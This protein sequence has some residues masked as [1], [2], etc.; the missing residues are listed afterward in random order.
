MIQPMPAVVL[1]R[2]GSMRLKEKWRLSWSNGNLVENAIRQT[3]ACKH[4][5]KV[6]VGS[7]SEELLGLIT[8]RFGHGSRETNSRDKAGF[9]RT[10][11]VLRPRVPS[12]QTSLD[13]LQFVLEQHGLQASY[14]LL[15]QSTFPF[16]SP[17]DLDALVEGWHASGACEGIFLSK[18]GEPSKP[19]GAAWIIHPYLGYGPKSFVPVTSPCIDIDTRED[20]DAAIAERARLEKRNDVRAM[21]HSRG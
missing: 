9:P 20:Y 15:V 5:S 17:L 7:D 21:D 6:Y 8:K 13:G 11:C 18:P 10:V 12:E 1:V 19:A 14:C 4:V 16:L 3:L 2:Q